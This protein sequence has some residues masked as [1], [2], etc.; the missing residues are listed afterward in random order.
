MLHGV[1]TGRERSDTSVKSTPVAGADIVGV[2]VCLPEQISPRLRDHTPDYLA[3]AFCLDSIVGITDL[4]YFFLEIIV[5][6]RNVRQ[7]HVFRQ[8][9]GFRCFKSIESAVALTYGIIK[10][11][12]T[13]IP[14]TFPFLAAILAADQFISISRRLVFYIYPVAVGE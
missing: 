3:I 12:L 4:H 1:E 9:L 13:G 7:R 10:S 8:T 5:D 6:T 11:L 14:G 2:H